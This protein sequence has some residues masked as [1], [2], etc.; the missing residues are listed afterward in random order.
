[1]SKGGNW[2][3]ALAALAA[4]AATGCG[5][6]RALVIFFG[7]LGWAS[8]PG[9]ALASAAF[10]LMAGLVARLC[11]RAGADN[12]AALCRRSLGRGGARVVGVFHALMLAAVA[13]VALTNAGEAGAL[14]L[15]VKRGFLWGMGLA[16]ALAALL[17]LW[18]RQALPW[19]GL[20]IL[21]VGAAFCAALAIDPRPPRLYLR[22]DVVP[23]L[24]GS[25]PAAAG[26]ALCYA[27]LNGCVAADAV[28]R[29]SDG[30]ARP[31]RTGFLSGA[32]MALTLALGNAML[33]SGGPMLLALAAPAVPLAA[34]W[35]LVGF[36][37]CA[38]LAFFCNVL[39][40][41]AAMGGLMGWLGR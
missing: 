41:S 31:V 3:V 39:T 10:G 1:M 23:A 9:I 24:A 36:W 14:T 15:P 20:I 13:V 8:W 11:A 30:S 19:A 22:G 16:L 17:C 5:S 32:G 7:Q 4:S 33:A 18:E 28:C 34:R 25:L 21:A 2:R 12:F 6:G 38:S 26:L 27:A 29:C 40:L 37:L 35:G